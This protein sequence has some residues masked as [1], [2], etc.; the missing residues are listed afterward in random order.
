MRPPRGSASA[1]RALAA[2]AT[3]LSLISSVATADAPNVWNLAESNLANAVMRARTA[4]GSLGGV[5]AVSQGIYTLA[6]QDHPMYMYIMSLLLSSGSHNARSTIF[7][8][9][10]GIC[11]GEIT[12]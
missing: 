9:P 2:V 3:A 8:I 6:T 11:K 12:P 4:S 10:R 1:A 5:Y 7:H